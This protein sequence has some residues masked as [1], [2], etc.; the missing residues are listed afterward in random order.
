MAEKTKGQLQTDIDDEIYSGKPGKIKGDEHNTVL[1]DMNDSKLDRLDNTLAFGDDQDT[2]KVIE[3]RTTGTV[4]NRP[5]IRYNTTSD[6]WEFSNDGSTW[7]EF[8]SGGGGHTIENDGTALNQRDNLNFKGSLVATD[9]DPD[10]DV[11]VADGGIDTTELADGAVATA[12]IQD[13]AVTNAKLA[14]DSVTTAKIADAN[15]TT[16]KVA[17]D[18][19]TNAKLANMGAYEVKGRAAGSGDPQDLSTTD[20]ED[21]G[22]STATM[23]VNGNRLWFPGTLYRAFKAITQ[24]AASSTDVT[25]FNATTG[26]YFT[27]AASYP[28]DSTGGSEFFPAGYLTDGMKVEAVFK[29]LAEHNGASGVVFELDLEGT[30]RHTH[31][32]GSI[33]AGST[34]YKLTMEMTVEAQDPTTGILQIV[35]RYEYDGGV[36]V[37]RSRVT[38]IDTSSAASF[39]VKA[40][41]GASQTV[42]VDSSEVLVYG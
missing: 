32:C 6:K 19:V 1:T 20:A 7:N 8:G 12:K 16:A 27:G 21:Q 42:D 33:A 39:N 2:N 35:S 14:T 3:A 31:T 24:I 28:N 17:D 4:G 18:A 22:H 10:T 41:T 23:L 25:L 15:V 40:T 11:D 34:P 38:G 37:K 9:N 26:E 29:G 36:E 30:T 5:K 13:D